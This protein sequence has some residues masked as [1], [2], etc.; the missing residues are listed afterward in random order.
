MPRE[1]LATSDLLIVAYLRSSLCVPLFPKLQ[2]VDEKSFPVY[3]ELVN[4][5]SFYRIDADDY[6][7]E[8]QR[9]G[10]KYIIHEVRAKILPERLQISDMLADDGSRYRRISADEFNRSVQHLASTAQRIY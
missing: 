9:I 8:Y 3:L 7:T 10:S 1:P 5:H 4:A 6:M 2:P